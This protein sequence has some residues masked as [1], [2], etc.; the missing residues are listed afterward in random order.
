MKRRWGQTFQRVRAECPRY[1][2]LDIHSTHCSNRYHS[3]NT[4]S[5]L[6]GKAAKKK[7]RMLD[8]VKQLSQ[9]FSIKEVI[10]PV[11]MITSLPHHILLLSLV[12]FF[13]CFFFVGVVL[14]PVLLAS[15]LVRYS[16]TQSGQGSRE[17]TILYLCCF[18][19]DVS[20]VSLGSFPVL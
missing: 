17:K 2:T 8:L 10:T 19:H 4:A 12:A 7:S 16:S 1:Q 3:T 9:E 13:F 18:G 14:A 20:R 5:A 15:R 6:E 11:L